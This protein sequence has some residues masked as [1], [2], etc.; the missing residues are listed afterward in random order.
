MVRILS[1][2]IHCDH[3]SELGEGPLWDYRTATMYWI[4]IKG[5]HLHSMVA[6]THDLMQM[7][8]QIGT[9]ALDLHGH[10]IVGLEDGV[11]RLSVAGALELLYSLDRK[12]DQVRCNDGKVDPFGKLVQGTMADPPDA[13]SG[14]L[15]RFGGPG[16]GEVL[17]APTLISNGMDWTDDQDFMW[18]ID[19]LTHSVRGY[20]YADGEPLGEPVR[21]HMIPKR[22]GAPDGMTLDADGFLWIALWGGY[23]VIRM[24]PDGA[25]DAFVEVPA[26]NVT[27]C[28]FAGSDLD[29]LVITSASKPASE[30]EHLP[31]AGKTFVADVAT[32]GRRANQFVG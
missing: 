10:L 7:P 1:V 2:D 15:M 27:A 25:I 13:D 26:A 16:N 30:G 12:H 18:Y 23:G 3:V 6:G 17:I 22:F 9:V 28:A 32:T 11:Y 21:T 14:S 19:T 4:D 29:Q 20:A 5:C 31:H 8:S 24:R